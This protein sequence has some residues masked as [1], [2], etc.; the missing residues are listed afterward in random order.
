M[1]TKVEEACLLALYAGVLEI[2]DIDKGEKPFRYT[3]GKRGPGYVHIRDLIGKGSA[4]KWLM[5][6]LA[7]KV[8]GKIRNTDKQR[9]YFVA[10][11]ATGGIVPGWILHEFLQTYLQQDMTCMYINHEKKSIAGM[12]DKFEQD[13][14]VLIVDDVVNFAHTTQKSIEVFRKLGCSVTHAVCILFYNNP[15]VQSDLEKM[16]VE[17]TYLFTVDDLLTTAERHKT[18]PQKLIASFREFTKDPTA[19]QLKRNFSSAN[20]QNAAACCSKPQCGC[21]H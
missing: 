3:S 18:H 13:D 15:N 17:L 20:K 12:P 6:Q 16:G 14:H 21:S 9:S 1:L 8:V 2:R 4:L 11:N 10:A 5:Q 19:W 7:L